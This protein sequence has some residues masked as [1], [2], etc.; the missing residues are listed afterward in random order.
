MGMAILMLIWCEIDG[1]YLEIIMLIVDVCRRQ[2]F[3][4]LFHIFQQ[5]RFMFI[6]DNCRGGMFGL[7]IDK[8]ICHTGPVHYIDHI[9]SKVDKLK[10]FAGHQMDSLMTDDETGTFTIASKHSNH[11][12]LLIL[13]GFFSITAG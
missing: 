1:A 12:S 4:H 13:N 9:I 8:T 11:M 5:E 3:Q 10:C 2:S 7:D 6:D